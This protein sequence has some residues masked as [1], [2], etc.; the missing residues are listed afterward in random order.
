MVAKKGCDSAV[1]VNRRLEVVD[2]HLHL[3]TRPECLPQ[4]RRINKELE[5][6]SPENGFAAARDAAQSDQRCRN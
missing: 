5:N 2:L 3:E 6:P 1:A 4:L